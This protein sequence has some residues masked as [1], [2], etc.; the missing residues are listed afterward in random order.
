[1]KAA[2][3]LLAVVLLGAGLF[4]VDRSLSQQAL[5]VAVDGKYK[6]AAEGWA[7]VTAAWPLALLAFVLVA[8]V[9]VPVLYVMASKVVHA[10]EDEISAIYKQKTAALDAEAKKRNDDF[11][12]KLA[13]LAE[14]EAKLARDIEELKQVKVKMATYVQDVNEKASDAERRRVNAAAAAE[15]RRRK[16]EKLQNAPS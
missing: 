14:R 5:A 6:V 1:M 15:R 4:I 11:K 2:L 7:I 10:R 16:L 12:A 3:I 13:N 9:T 8:A